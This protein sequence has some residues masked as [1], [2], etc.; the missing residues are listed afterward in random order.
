MCRGYNKNINNNCETGF[1]RVGRYE[2]VAAYRNLLGVK[3][4]KYKVFRESYSYA[5]MV[6]IVIMRL[7][8]RLW[9]HIRI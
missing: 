7:V 6:W 3:E 4:D 5:L 8:N 9:M 2:L 1:A